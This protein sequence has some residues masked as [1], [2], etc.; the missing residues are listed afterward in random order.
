M[1]ASLVTVTYEN[2]HDGSY[3]SFLFRSEEEADEFKA[4]MRLLKRVWATLQSPTNSDEAWALLNWW[5]RLDRYRAV[6][7]DEG[8]PK[9]IWRRKRV[10]SRW[11]GQW[12]RRLERT[13]GVN[14]INA[15]PAA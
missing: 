12:I 1:D 10:A 7:T 5:R 9:D 8:I 13:R 11:A 3:E 14:G 6:Y 2:D 15:A 4:R